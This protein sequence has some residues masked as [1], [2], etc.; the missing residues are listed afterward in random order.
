MREMVLRATQKDRVGREAGG[1]GGWGTV[2]E[3]LAEKGHLST[4]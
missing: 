4:A 3:G 2:R 1:T